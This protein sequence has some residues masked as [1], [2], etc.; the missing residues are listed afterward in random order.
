MNPIHIY[1][2]TFNAKLAL[3]KKIFLPFLDNITMEDIYKFYDT[4]TNNTKLSRKL[5][6]NG[7]EPEYF[8][9]LEKDDFIKM[10][11][12]EGDCAVILKYKTKIKKEPTPPT[13]P[14]ENPYR[15]IRRFL[16]PAN[17]VYLLAKICVIFLWSYFY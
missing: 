8:H 9:L 15:K 13:D 10:G 2:H 6:D 5:R 1:S 17:Q 7:L 14:G 3:G 12:S 11:F 4:L 16:Q